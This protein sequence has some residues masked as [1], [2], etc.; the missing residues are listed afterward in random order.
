MS[1]KILTLWGKCDIIVQLIISCI[2]LIN[3]IDE[4]KIIGVFPSGSYTLA[5]VP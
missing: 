2:R 1:R 3:A 5:Y 4:Q